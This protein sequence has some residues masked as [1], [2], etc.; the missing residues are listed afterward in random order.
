MLHL[1]DLTDPGGVGPGRCHQLLAQ[2]SDVG[3]KKRTLA[4]SEPA[5]ITFSPRSITH[6]E[7]AQRNNVERNNVTLCNREDPLKPHRVT[8]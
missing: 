7:L 8:C 5:L 1:D 4:P 3:A 2:G 6:G